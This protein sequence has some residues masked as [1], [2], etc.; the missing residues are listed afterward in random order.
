MSPATRFIKD[1]A[2]FASRLAAILA[3]VYLPE[4]EFGF[5]ISSGF[6]AVFACLLS[7]GGAERPRMTET[8]PL[9]LLGLIFFYIWAFFQSLDERGDTWIESNR[10]RVVWEALS[11]IPLAVT[12][13][14]L[15][16]T[17][18]ND[19]DQLGVFGQTWCLLM[20]Q[21]EAHEDEKPDTN[22]ADEKLLLV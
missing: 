10:T 20:S 16:I 8:Y 19:M 22:N 11:V 5:H 6:K 15:A 2:F 14:S 18:N 9:F 12:T 7:L 21:E 17:A 3:L 1:P 13:F 4:Q